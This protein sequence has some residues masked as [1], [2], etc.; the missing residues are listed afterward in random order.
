MN[1]WL[2]DKRLKLAA[3]SVAGLGY[4]AVALLSWLPA[5]YRP[6]IVVVSDKLE[7][8]LAY[9]LL[10]A[11]TAIAARRTLNASWLAL[12]IVAYA[13]VLELGQLLI[14]SRV[15]SVGDFVASAAGAIVGVLI[16]SLWRPARRD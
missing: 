13:G 14:P 1:N 3:L 10:G 11:L 9:L 6:H 16:A 7:H 5:A 4:V 15:A 8:A 2:S 12:A